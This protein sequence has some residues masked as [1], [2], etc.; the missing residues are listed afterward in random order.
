MRLYT[1]KFPIMSGF[2]CVQ[3]DNTILEGDVKILWKEGKIFK[4]K[5][6][7]QNFL[8]LECEGKITQV[9]ADLFSVAFEETELNF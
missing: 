5:C 3:P 8:L 1:N 7:D 4:V 9:N 6:I 2:L